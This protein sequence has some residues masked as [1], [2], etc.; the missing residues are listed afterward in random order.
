VF[1]ILG[2][3]TPIVVTWTARNAPASSLIVATDTE[4]DRERLRTVLAD[5]SALLLNVSPELGI[6]IGTSYIAVGTVRPVRRSNVGTLPLWD[7]ELPYQVVGRPA[8]GTQAART[9]NTV[10]GQY[11]SWNAEAAANDSWAELVAPTG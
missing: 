7:F 10:A 6:G 1:H 4:R 8:G 11:A 3:E 5:G 9:W 2:R